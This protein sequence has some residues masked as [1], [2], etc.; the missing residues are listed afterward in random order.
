MG[1]GDGAHSGRVWYCR[2]S[3]G[4]PSAT[5]PSPGYGSVHPK[6][7]DRVCEM[8]NGETPRMVLEAS[9]ASTMRATPVPPRYRQHTPTR[10][11]QA[12]KTRRDGE[13]GDNARTLIE[14]LHREPCLDGRYANI[15]VINRDSRTGDRRGHQ[16]ALSVV[17][18]AIDTRTGKPVALKF[19]DPDFL[20]FSARYRMDLFDRECR[21]LERLVNKPRCLQL[22]QP[23]SELRLS[24]PGVS[25]SRSTTIDCG[26][27]V[28][29]WLDGDITEYFLRQDEH[30]ALVKLALFRQAVLGVFALHR[31]GIAHRDI[32]HDNLRRTHR[33]NR[34]MVIPIDLGTAVDLLSDPIGDIRD[35]ADP[36]GAW[37]FSPIEAH[38]GLGSIRTLAAYTDVYALGCLLHDLFNVE[39]YVARLVKD[40]GFN[41]C[42]MAC[43][44]HMDAVR[45]RTADPEGHVRE[46]D[47]IIVRTKSQITLPPIDSAAT[48]VPP[49]VRDQ[50]NALLHRLTDADYRRREH[51]PDRIVRIIDAAVKALENR[52]TIERQQARRAERRRRRE[53]RAKRQQER[54]DFYLKKKQEGVPSS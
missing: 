45:S 5:P 52:F 19:F 35:Y 46:W 44:A 3:F 22:V 16:G 11:R 25:R 14:M 7:P 54:L 28:L 31:E 23:L 21:L 4:P 51:R 29:E 10:S 15:R 27:C 18:H 34:E 2:C 37:A 36:V 50:L 32:K 17:F 13:L 24:V 41:N 26:Y 53:H 33:M 39:L 12:K 20:G 40:P 42:Y 8:Q 38:G 30:D 48:T 6:L 47:D 9:S 49:A 43:R 1:C